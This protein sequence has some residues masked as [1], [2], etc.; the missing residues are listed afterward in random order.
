MWIMV[1]VWPRILRLLWHWTN[2]TLP[3]MSLLLQNITQSLLVIHNCNLDLTS[4]HLYV[5]L[6]LSIDHIHLQMHISSFNNCISPLVVVWLW[7]VWNGQKKISR[8]YHLECRN[9]NFLLSLSNFMKCMH[10]ISF[11]CQPERQWVW[12][13]YWDSCH[14]MI[15]L[16]ISDQ[17]PC[18]SYSIV[19]VSL[20]NT[21]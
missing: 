21:S 2:M 13:L 5:H 9:H 3:D 17:C 4:H 16:W 14:P 1:W 6:Y 18:K 12:V 19:Q 7:V 10:R 11:H 8:P 20:Q 15:S